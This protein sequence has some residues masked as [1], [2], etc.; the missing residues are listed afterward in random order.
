MASL[1]DR[2]PYLIYFE[3]TVIRETPNLTDDSL[4]RFRHLVPLRLRVFAR[5]TK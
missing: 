1:K 3:N 4:L 5:P 2:V